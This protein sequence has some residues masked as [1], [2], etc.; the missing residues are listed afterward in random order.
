ML[1][2][3]MISSK[4][5][6]TNATLINDAACDGSGCEKNS[7]ALQEY[8]DELAVLYDSQVDGLFVMDLK[9]KSF[10]RF[11]K[12][13]LD[14]LGYSEAEMLEIRAESIHPPDKVAEVMDHFAAMAVAREQ[15]TQDIPCVRKDGSTFN[16]DISARMAVFRGGP[17]LVGF[18]HDTTERKQVEDNLRQSKAQLEASNEDL[19]KAIER[20]NE[21]TAK[22]ESANRVKSQFLANMSHEIRTPMNGIIG[23]TGL[24]LDTNLTPRQQQYAEIIRNSSESLLAIINDILDFSK[25]E[26]GCLELETVDFDL[27]ELMEDFS[28]A[29]AIR[30]HEKELEITCFVH[31]STP[32]LLSGY[33]GRLRQ[34]LTNLVG[35]AI[36]FTDVG[37]VAMSVETAWQNEEQIMLR[38]CVKDT[39]IGIPPEHHKSIMSPFVQA[40]GSI[41]RKYG[42]TGLG[43][44]IS[45]QLTEMMGGELTLESEEGKGSTFQFTVILKKQSL[46]EDRQKALFP[47]AAKAIGDIR[48]LTVD[49]NETNTRLMYEIMK[50]WG[51][52]CETAKSSDKAIALLRAAAMAEDPYHVVIIDTA[53]TGVDIVKVCKQIRGVSKTDTV[54][55]VAMVPFGRNYSLRHFRSIGFDDCITKPIKPSELFDCLAGIFAPHVHRRHKESSVYDPNQPARKS[56]KKAR[57]LVAEDNTTNQQ[58]ARAIIE[59]LGYRV[60]LVADGKE[61]IKVLSDLP[62]DIVFMDCQMPGMD[63][64]EATEAIRAENSPVLNHKIPIIA[65]TAHAMVGYREKCLDSGMDDFV[66]KPVNPRSV[67]DVIEKWLSPKKKAR[68]GKGKSA[69][70]QVEVV[71]AENNNEDPNDTPYIPVFNRSTLL[72]RLSGNE[73]LF[74]TIID[75]FLID[76]PSRISS[77]KDALT[78]N[79]LDSARIQAHTIKG[80]SANIAALALREV[81]EKL[82]HACSSHEPDPLPD[83]TLQL[84]R[85][86][87]ILRE[88]LTQP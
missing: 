24:L 39:G 54:Y 64:F 38:F 49:S 59:K 37:E 25:I 18:L 26:A 19:E 6:R 88:N 68:A 10:L 20:A 48:I 51:V 13:F 62:Y 31:P 82:E 33:P 36:K 50:H 61:A 32:A 41:T 56:R 80:A 58:V 46:Q 27:Y 17:V 40:D 28:N 44:A 29:M 74:K 47:K 14:M 84:E 83:L 71:P 8:A 79:D 43:L 70:S 34:I 3:G 12:A 77:L 81:A 76:I 4:T 78:H 9:T 30:A 23:M 69:N 35:N 52:R 15:L 73:K 65:M 2:R 53:I 42:G 21:M 75:Q 87:D 86:F 22:A 72:E 85:Q 1:N 63:G 57:I 55:A 66:A 5:L 11:N 45:K 7:A 67:A 16:A 60:D